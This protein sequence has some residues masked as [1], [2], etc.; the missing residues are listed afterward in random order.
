VHDHVQREDERIEGFRDLLAGTLQANAAQVSV[1]QNEIVQK[2]S[3]WAAI[4]AVPT[5]ISGI[6]GM[7]FDHMPELRWPLG[8]PFALTMMF[9]L[10]GA[11]YLLLR[12]IRWL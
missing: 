3:G 9:G 10:A 11:L 12:R 2:I 1:R 5:L 6:Y 8:Y 7:N 4:I